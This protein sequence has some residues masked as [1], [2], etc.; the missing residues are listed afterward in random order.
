MELTVAFL[1]ATVATVF[2]VD[3]AADFRRR[4]RPHVA[5]YTTGIAMFA[6]ATWALAAALLVGWNGFNYR[7]FFL[8]GAVLNVPFLALGSTFLVLGRR[9]GHVFFFVVGALTAMATTLVTTTPFSNTLPGAGIP[10]D[11]FGEGFSFGPRLLALIAGAGFG[12]ILAA[13]GIVG[14]VKLWKSNRNIAVGN[15]MIVGGAFAAAWGGTGLGFLGEAGAFAVSLL[16]A[17]TLLWAGYRYTRRARA[18]TP[19]P[20]LVVLVGPSIR[21]PERA[22]T[23]QLISELEN[24]GL[25]VRCPA[26]DI[27][28]WGAVGFGPAEANRKLL[29]LVADADALLIDLVDNYGV[30][31]PAGYA[32]A[33]GIPVLVA[34]S[35]GNR[36]PRPFRGVA[37]TEIYYNS[38]AE[39][40]TRVKASLESVTKT[41]K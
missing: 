28:D 17:S 14:I 18:A 21:S 19:A 38:P 7:I 2:T 25:R 13:L 1:A 12:T 10:H 35:E 8:F 16:A 4:P 20:P 27:E 33:K 24:L 41:H 29:E 34:I 5:A 32:A 11:A 15:A 39:V 37:T 31:V 40:A 26:R 22:H 6:V 36:I 3:L 9:T 23:E 30:G